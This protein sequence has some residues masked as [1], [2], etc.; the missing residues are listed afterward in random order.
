MNVSLG[1]ETKEDILDRENCVYIGIA[2]SI[3]GKSGKLCMA[4]AGA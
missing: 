3:I 4:G 2:W 1:I